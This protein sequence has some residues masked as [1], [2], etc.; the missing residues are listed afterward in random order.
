MFC[1]QLPLQR[2]GLECWGALLD[3]PAR[4]FFFFF[5][6]SIPLSVLSSGS[7][8][9]WR[10]GDHG[11]TCCCWLTPQHGV[12]WHAVLGA[13]LQYARTHTHKRMHVRMHAHT[14]LYT[15]VCTNGPE[16]AP[17]MPLCLDAALVWLL[18]PNKRVCVHPPP[19]PP[20]LQPRRSCHRWVTSSP[21]LLP[22]WPC[23]Q[24]ELWGLSI[25]HSGPL[26]TPTN[27]QCSCRLRKEVSHLASAD[28]KWIMSH[29][30]SNLI[31]HPHRE[32]TSTQEG[33]VSHT[34]HHSEE[35]QI[36]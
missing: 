22:R 29:S 11:D 25:R 7:M 15:P 9:K 36:Q 16:D 33:R 19:A 30:W 31:S 2:I 6:M 10:G 35:G 14:W 20:P 24:R 1:L 13:T 32:K 18:S 26:C 34:W 4:I 28:L 21:L 8:W 17:L 3:L 23:Q 5:C 27:P 12:P